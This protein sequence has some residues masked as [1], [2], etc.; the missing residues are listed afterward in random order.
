MTRGKSPGRRLAAGSHGFSDVTVGD[1]L[2]TGETQITAALIDGFANLCGDRF[3]IHMSDDA[4]ARHGFPGRV[5][6]GLLV[7]SVVDGL[8][9]A[10]DAQFKAVA[11]LNWDW[12]FRRPVIAGD[13]IQVRVTV[14][15][16][17]QTRKQDRGILRLG[18]TVSNQRGELVQEGENLLMVYA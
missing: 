6:H 10:A 18:F 14:L 12:S 9:N 2:E 13:T 15:E 7:L 1:W 11:S 16:K 17:R 8:K 3:E 4:A 5:A